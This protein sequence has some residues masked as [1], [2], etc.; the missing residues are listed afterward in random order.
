M[1]LAALDLEV[2]VLLALLLHEPLAMLVDVVGHLGQAR[3]HAG[4]DPRAVHVHVPRL[5][6]APIEAVSQERAGIDRDREALRSPRFYSRAMQYTKRFA[7]AAVFLLREETD[8]S[9]LLRR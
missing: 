6:P 5:V 7:S 2:Q 8:F 4:R 3:Y 1:V 9:R